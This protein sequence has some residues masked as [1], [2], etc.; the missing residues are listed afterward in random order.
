MRNFIIL[1]AGIFFFSSAI[2]QETEYKSKETCPF[3]VAN[4]EALTNDGEYYTF[5]KISPDG[6]KVMF[7]KSSNKGIYVVDLNSKGQI[8]TI[9]EESV[10]GSILEWSKDGSFLTYRTRGNKNN[11]SVTENKFVYNLIDDKKEIFSR[12]NTKEQNIE[13]TLNVRERKAEASDGINK[14]FIT[15]EPGRYFGFVISPDNS[16]VIIRS[17]HIYIYSIDGNE[18]IDTGLDTGMATDWSPDGNYFLYYVEKDDGHTYL[19]SDLYVCSAD[20]KNKWKLTSTNDI[21]EAR[22]TWSV[23]GNKISFVDYSTGKIF[24]AELKTK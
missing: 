7:T 11:K 13:V 1:I 21:M 22:P 23:S 2:A 4:Y 18:I 3:E 5:P 20:G 6:T 9:T 19:E 15:K 16:K 17:N 8:K 14:W 10:Y 24:I 12:T